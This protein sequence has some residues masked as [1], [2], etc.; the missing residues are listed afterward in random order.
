MKRDEVL[1]IREIRPTGVYQAIVQENVHP[2]GDKPGMVKVMV[3]AIHGM[4]DG[5][6]AH[7]AYPPDQGYDYGTMCVPEVG[8]IVYVLFENGDYA[9]PVVIGSHIRWETEVGHEYS[10]KDGKWDAAAKD[11]SDMFEE[12]WQCEKEKVHFKKCVYKSV[13][14]HALLMDDEHGKEKL[15]LLDRAGNTFYMQAGKD[16]FDYGNHRQDKMMIHKTKPGYTPEQVKDGKSKVGLRDIANQI[17]RYLVDGVGKSLV[18]IVS[19]TFLGT[20]KAGLLMRNFEDPESVLF[21]TLEMG[22]GYKLQYSKGSTLELKLFVGSTNVFNLTSVA[23]ATEMSSSKGLTLSSNVAV[24]VTAPV[25]SISAG[26]VSISSATT[27]NFSGFSTGALGSNLNGGPYEFED[28]EQE[29]I[30]GLK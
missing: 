11:R 23:G 10:S 30:D 4:G 15:L 2:S 9:Y 19:R 17:M 28:K 26:V 29:K 7:V 27:I 13:K 3:P 5:A 1:G 22:N 8:T 21:H 14:G 20:K 24:T 25:V 6:W 18:E 16:E 12:A